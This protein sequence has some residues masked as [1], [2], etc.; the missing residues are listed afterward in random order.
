MAAEDSSYQGAASQDVSQES[1]SFEDADLSIPKDPDKEEHN[2]ESLTKDRVQ[3]NIVEGSSADQDEYLNKE[4]AQDISGEDK[5]LG[6]ESTS[7]VALEK[8]SF[9]DVSEE[10]V[11][12]ADSV[13]EPE[14]PSPG[15]ENA[16]ARKLS[17]E[18]I[19]VGKIPGIEVSIQG[20]SDDCEITDDN[21]LDIELP[22]YQ[23]EVKCELEED[24][25]EYEP[26]DSPSTSHQSYP[27]EFKLEPVEDPDE[28][29][30]IRCEL[31]PGQ[32]FDSPEILNHHARKVHNKKVQA[33]VYSIADR[34]KRN[35]RDSSKIE[36]FSSLKGNKGLKRKY[37]RRSENDDL[38]VLILKQE[39]PEIEKVYP[40]K[41][42][43]IADKRRR[44]KKQDSENSVCEICA[45]SYRH[46]RSLQTHIQRV[47]DNEKRYFCTR[48]SYASYHRKDLE[49]HMRS[50]N[51][52]RDQLKR[53]QRGIQKIEVWENGKQYFKCQICD[54]NLSDFR[55][56][57]EHIQVVHRKQH[58]HHCE[59]CGKS[60]GTRG[61]LKLHL[62]SMHKAKIEKQ[63]PYF[64]CEN[65]GKGFY[66]KKLLQEHANTCFV[67]VSEGH[68]ENLQ[69]FFCEDCGQVFSYEQLYLRHKTSHDPQW[70]CPARQV[71]IKQPSSTPSEHSNMSVKRESESDDEE[72]DRILEEES[73]ELNDE[74]Y[75]KLQCKS[76]TGAES[77]SHIRKNHP[78]QKR[79]RQA[80]ETHGSKAGKPLKRVKKEESGEN[81]VC[82]ICAKSYRH[83]RSLITHVKRVHELE[84]RYFCHRCSYASYHRKDLEGHLRSKLGCEAQIKR[85][86]RG[87][88]K[89]EVMENGKIF[90]KCEICDKKLSDYYH[91]VDHVK[92]VHWNQRDYHCDQCGKSFGVLSSLKLHLQSVHN[93]VSAKKPPTF[94]CEHCSQG[95]YARKH[96]DAHS[97]SCP[98]K[99]VT[100]E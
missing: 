60:F 66:Q 47:H 78:P 91:V 92:I 30:I 42:L 56:V 23:V 48:C 7:G 51:G 87:V 62:Q 98:K 20:A 83:P 21:G 59:E 27:G 31:C 11:A 95:F 52:C 32:I 76:E 93:V 33:K 89:I 80:K 26:L 75:D 34:R 35:G 41:I 46:A 65:C 100:A 19:L 72:D 29:G 5:Q 63:A 55:H 71:V 79:K 97:D 8:E 69:K 67:P 81:S 37:Q 77:R 96:F 15:T 13:K 53:D 86:S 40:Q 74:T 3:E 44:K 16:K 88:K 82:D 84:K 17:V 24:G 94:I 70:M 50:Q 90:Y 2:Q 18:D 43:N 36:N 25:D 6:T 54:K 49:G 57:V 10:E 9:K 28:Q 39:E 4:T 61:G 64:I 73:F 58:D 38:N 85:D 1:V 12:Q 45:K 68:Y 14:T 99:N 22:G